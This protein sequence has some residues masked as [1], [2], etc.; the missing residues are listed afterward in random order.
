M[1]L[2]LD[3]IRRILPD[4][5]PLASLPKPF[6]L[7]EPA[8][9]LREGR[10]TKVEAARAGQTTQARINA[11]ASSADLLEDVVGP[12]PE[13]DEAVETKVRSTLGQ[14]LIG[15][16]AEQVF[17]DL[18]FGALGNGDLRLRDDRGARSDTDFLVEDPSGRRVFRLNI[19]FHGSTFRKAAEMVG[20][21]PHDTFALATYKIHGALE[22]QVAEHLQYIF[23]VIGVRGLTGATVGALIPEDLVRL[24]ALA[25]GSKKVEGKRS[26]EE[27]VV[28]RILDR[29]D[30]YGLRT[31]FAGIQTELGQAEWRVISARRADHLLRELLFER[32][33]ALRV[34]GFA[35]NYRGAE[36]D[37]HFSVSQDLHPLQDLFDTLR[38][39]G[40]PGLVTRLERGTL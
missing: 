22:K 3:D 18:W 2:S 31:N 32:A 29:P 14:L 35:Q 34:R 37:M 28:D 33:Y 4:V 21:D 25:H 30:T 26:I 16:M 19:K 11:L 38:D 10:L 9:A 23:V 39:H 1:I 17:Q 7:L 8:I 20:L 15:Q 40:M 13:F 27:A 12:L 5:F 6:G 24:V 36:L